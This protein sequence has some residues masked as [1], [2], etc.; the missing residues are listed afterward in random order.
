MYQKI[1]FKWRIACHSSATF[2]YL[3]KLSE[4]IVSYVNPFAT[5]RREGVNQEF[6]QTVTNDLVFFH[7]ISNLCGSTEMRN[8][9][10]NMP[11]KT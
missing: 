4:E 8:L 3:C 11:E 2:I 10:D 7:C 6:K 9:T 1:Q 5:E